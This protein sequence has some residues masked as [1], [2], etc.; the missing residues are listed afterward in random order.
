[1]KMVNKGKKM[2]RGIEVEHFE[3]D[4]GTTVLCDFCNKDYSDSDVSG[5]LL[6]QSKAACPSCESRMLESAKKYNEERF[7]KGYC[8]EGL[9]FKDWILSIRISS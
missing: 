4:A 5:G 2:F 6:F 1:M 3:L 7:I 8:P 9:S